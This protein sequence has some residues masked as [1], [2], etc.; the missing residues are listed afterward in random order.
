MGFDAQKV[1]AR[2]AIHCL[3]EE[4]TSNRDK[5]VLSGTNREQHLE[6]LREIISK[7]DLQKCSRS[8][9]QVSR[10][11]PRE[12]ETT[13]NNAIKLHHKKGP[14]L[15]NERL[16]DF[17]RMGKDCF[18]ESYQQ[19]LDEAR[20]HLP[21]LKMQLAEAEL[22]ATG[23]AEP[24][25][26]KMRLTASQARHLRD[27]KKCHKPSRSQKRRAY[28]QPDN[29]SGRRSHDMWGKQLE[30]DDRD[31]SADQNATQR[32]IYGSDF[33][34]TQPASNH[35]PQMPDV[36]KTPQ[37]QNTI[38]GS[39]PFAVAYQ[40][41]VWT[42]YESNSPNRC[43]YVGDED[44]KKMLKGL[45]YDLTQVIVGLEGD[46]ERGWVR[47]QSSIVTEPCNEL[48]TI[49]R[50]VFG[51]ETW[52]Q[53]YVKISQVCSPMI[54]LKAI[55]AAAIYEQIFSRKLEDEGVALELPD[56][57]ALKSHLRS[58]RVDPN[59]LLAEA[60]DKRCEE[61]DF[62]RKA[63]T[64]ARDICRILHPHLEAMELPNS[65]YR[66]VTHL[67]LLGS[68]LQ[69]LT[70]CATRI[71]ARLAMAVNEF[72][73]FWADVGNLWNKTET[74][75]RLWES[76]GLKVK[77]KDERQYRILLDPKSQQCGAPAQN[78][79]SLVTTPA[80]FLGTPPDAMPV[81]QG[82]ELSTQLAPTYVPTY[83]GFMNVDI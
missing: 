61:Y 58:R 19:Q 4:V 51:N 5:F 30:I 65:P 16:S 54:V 11:E 75:G 52:L 55:I 33:S 71:K 76:P 3:S 12:L 57:H 56:W 32:A 80:C 1:F 47:D 62:S 20:T 10:Y 6:H 34:M 77:H 53:S 46:I 48:S 81:Q 63:D 2:V 50:L 18:T 24:N 25:E 8:G 15:S 69:R 44:A 40:S 60:T 64:H 35:Q 7:Y 29:V 42:L 36:Q 13:I 43:L 83:S 39:P 70:L 79:G 41:D 9:E 73:F 27:Q 28:E 21:T 23:N 37:H 59:E 17:F 67:Q 72:E 74:P 14:K 49:Y 22:F 38:A 68:Y 26:L 31:T 82:V 66:N 45:E 78:N